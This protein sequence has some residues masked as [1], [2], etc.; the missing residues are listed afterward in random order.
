MTGIAADDGATAAPPGPAITRRRLLSLAG[1]GAAGIGVGATA[2]VVAARATQSGG[3]GAAVVPFHGAHQAGVA[4]AVQGHLH[5]AAFDVVTDDRAELVGLLQDWTAAARAMTAGRRVGG[6]GLPPGGRLA[7]PGDTGEA[8]GLDPARLTLTVGF[9]PGLFDRRFGLAGRRPPALVDLPHF[10]G[11][12]LEPARCGGDLAVQA[13]SDDPQVAVHAVR[14]LTR[15]AA[16]RAAI[17]WAQLGFGKAS[18]TDTETPT[19]RNLFGFKDGTAN[20]LG[21]D[22][23]ALAEHVWAGP[24]AGWMTGGTYLVARRVRM[25]IET[26]DR[27]SLDEQE[28]IV[29]RT[30]EAGAPLGSTQERAP[31]RPGRLPADSHVA[32]AHPSRHDGVRMLRRGFSFVD[33]SDGLGHLDAGLFFLAYQRDPRTAFVPI[34]QTLARS[35]A[36]RE[37]LRHTGSSVWACPPGVHPAGWWGDTLLR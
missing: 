11:D 34:Q 28:H 3:G 4:T 13:C 27:S 25:T 35:D 17:R 26:W 6:S 29:G 7:P 15:I 16:G 14:N 36:M 12:V 22:A 37:Y 8:V 32:L 21:D 31:L 2:G 33:G 1:I 24:D 5:F 19:P 10:A 20:I 9:G 18:S 23:A 30:K